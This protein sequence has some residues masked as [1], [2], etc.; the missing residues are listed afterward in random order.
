VVGTRSDGLPLSTNFY[1][2]GTI[3]IT[4]T[5]TDACSNRSSC[6]FTITVRE[7]NGVIGTFTQG[8]WGNAG[9]LN[10]KPKL[11]KIAFMNCLIGSGITIGCSNTLFIAPGEALC[12]LRVMPGGGSVDTLPIGATLFTGGV[13]L[14]DGEC[15][16]NP[17]LLNPKTGRINNVLLSQTIALAFNLRL[18]ATNCTNY[19]NVCGLAP[20]G[21]YTL[22]TNNCT[23]APVRVNGCFTRDAGDKGTCQSF[24][25]DGTIFAALDTLYGHH[26]VADL[27]A[28]AN[29]ALG[30]CSTGGA[31]LND[32]ASAV[33][34]INEGFDE[35]RLPVDCSVCAP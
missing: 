28:L 5:A 12:V 35:F 3:T 17:V 27:L 14:G 1:P 19:L 26:T 29:R 15:N 4:Y 33:G 18:S 8:Y 32:I 20:L 2:V 16:V 30:G 24:S 9:N 13:G 34:A 6:N 23:T 10:K 25:I 22:K 21:D 7:C 11:D 31:S